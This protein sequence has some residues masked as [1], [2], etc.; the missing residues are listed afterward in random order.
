MSDDR[1]LK[2]T[3]EGERLIRA[4]KGAQTSLEEAKRE[5]TRA[6]ENVVESTRALG[7]WLMPR[8]A[9]K[10][11]KAA[12]W[13]LDTLIEAEMVDERTFVIRLREQG[14]EWNKL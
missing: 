7:Q 3:A 10:G 9:K 14:R 13:F 11:E 4:W 1:P 6:G 5:L 8:N 12:V 2:T